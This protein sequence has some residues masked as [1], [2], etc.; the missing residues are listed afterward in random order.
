VVAWCFAVFPGNAGPAAQTL[1][2]LGLLQDAY[3]AAPAFLDIPNS[4]CL[5]IASCSVLQCQHH[6]HHHGVLLGAMPFC[7]VA[8]PHPPPMFHPMQAGAGGSYPHTGQRVPSV[9]QW[10][11]T[12]HQP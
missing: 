6:H 9:P 1:H 12:R 7:S 2:H 10:L 11:V 4:C 3:T 5:V 8:P